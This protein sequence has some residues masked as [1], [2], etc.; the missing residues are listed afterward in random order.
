MTGEPVCRISGSVER[1]FL[2][3]FSSLTRS[4]SHS[5]RHPL[6]ELCV[7]SFVKNDLALVS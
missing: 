3:I 6:V 7:D 1:G 2:L 5:G 4:L